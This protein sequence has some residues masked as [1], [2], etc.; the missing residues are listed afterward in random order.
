MTNPGYSILPS[1]LTIQ[2]GAFYAQGQHESRAEQI[3]NFKKPFKTKCLTAQS[4]VQWD[5]SKSHAPDWY[6][7]KS[8]DKNKVVWSHS[9]PGRQWM[10]IGY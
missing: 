2:F 4:T 10:A 1:G 6:W 9:V 8:C 3:V 5:Y 7:V